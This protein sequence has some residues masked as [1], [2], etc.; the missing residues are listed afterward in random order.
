MAI[1]DGP[2]RSD[3]VPTQSG[4][5]PVCSPML[6]RVEVIKPL[7]ITT[8]LGSSQYIWRSGEASLHL[9]MANIAM[10]NPQKNGGL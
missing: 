9:V 6:G 1:K 8:L 3:D 5:F 2:K 10:E 4:D 7:C